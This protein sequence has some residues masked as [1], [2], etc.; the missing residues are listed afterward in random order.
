MPRRAI[1]LVRAAASLDRLLIAMII[2]SLV[3]GVV[4]GYSVL[5]L[6][7]YQRQPAGGVA[8]ETGE[9]NVTS[10]G[11]EIEIPLTMP[12]AEQGVVSSLRTENNAT[13]EKTPGMLYPR[14]RISG[15]ELLKLQGENGKIY[16]TIRLSIGGNLSDARDLVISRVALEPLPFPFAWN[17]SSWVYG[18]DEEKC[19]ARIALPVKI[20]SYSYNVSSAEDHSAIISLKLD[21][22]RANVY[23]RYSLSIVV[24]LGPNYY[25][26]AREIGLGGYVDPPGQSGTKIP[27]CS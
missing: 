26:I 15:A 9:I 21:L 2:A 7:P 16:F 5:Y 11:R 22:D 27:A 14:A 8:S 1:Y 13:T 3:L 4:V 17:G 18:A 10:G 25:N 20:T 24:K 23:G 6:Y 12:V 19:L